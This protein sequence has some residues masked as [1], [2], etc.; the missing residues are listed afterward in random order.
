M[1]LAIHRIAHALWRWRIPLLPKFLKI[2]NRIVFGVVLPPSVFVGKGVLFS[3]QGLGTVIH[4]SARIEDGAVVSTGVTIG[5]RSGLVGAPVIGAGA[6]IGTGAKVLGP[7]RVGRSASVG[8]NA[9]VLLDVPDFAV[10][11]GVPARI[12]RINRPEDVPRYDVFD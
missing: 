2:V 12:I 5:G 4:K 9:V 8:A 6:L 7:V 1:V 3:Y 10:V 11:A